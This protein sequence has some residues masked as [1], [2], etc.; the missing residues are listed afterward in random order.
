MTATP[1]QAATQRGGNAGKSV[2]MRGDAIHAC[3]AKHKQREQDQEKQRMTEMTIPEPVK[4]RKE[5]NVENIDERLFMEQ[6]RALASMVI[7][8]LWQVSK[9]KQRGRR[10]PVGKVHEQ[11]EECKASK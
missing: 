5:N 8:A 7:E 3:V 9:T 11:H 1:E 10:R 4:D 6:S 2:L